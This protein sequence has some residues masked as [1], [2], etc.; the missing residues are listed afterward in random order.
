MR[1]APSSI[2]DFGAF[3][4]HDT[5]ASRLHAK[6]GRKVGFWAQLAGLSGSRR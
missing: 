6:H 2:Q 4:T 5:F 1:V 3:E